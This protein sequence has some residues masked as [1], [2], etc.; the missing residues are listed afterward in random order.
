MT[1]TGETPESFPRQSARTRRFTLGEPRSF[2]ICGEGRR[3][4]FLRALSGTDA[5]TALWALDPVDG[6]ER[7]VVDP[8]TLGEDADLPE[9]ERA[10]RERVRETASGVVAYATDDAGET[11]AFAAAGVLW[12]VDVTGGEPRRLPAAPG[13]YDPRPD[14]TGTHI[15][16]VSGRELRVIAADGTGDRRIAGEDAE[17]VSW[18]R[19]EFV[20]AEEMDRQRGY[21]WSPDG[22]ALLAARVDE[23]PVPVWWIADPA[24][25]DRPPT[26][27]RYPAAGTDNAE[28]SLHVLGLDGDTREITWD[29]DGFPYL[30][31]VSW[32][33]A[34]PPLLQVQTRD[35]RTTR[36]L[37]VD[38]G[39]GDTSLVVE[40]TD[41]VWV[42][43]FP[44]VPA[45]SGDDVVR[46]ADV[47]GA[48]RLIVG[49]RPVTDPGLYVRGVVSADGSGVVFTASL[50]VPSEVHVARWTPDGVE[51]LT[52]GHTV[53]A[54]VAGEGVLVLSTASLE[55]HGYRHRLLAAGTEHAITSVVEA[56]SIE[57]AVRLLRLGERRLPAG[58]LLPRDHVPGTR[59]PVLLDP[60]GGPHA[61]RVL[62]ARRVWLESQW[63]ADQGF[64]VLVA[65]GRGTPGVGP[66]WERAV[67]RDIAE[68]VLADQAD[69]LAA[70]A[71]VE[72]DLDLGR[73]AIR[74]WSFGGYLA[75]LA[76][77]RRPDLFH[78]AVA[79]APSA[80][81]A[82]YDTHYTERYLGLPQDEPEAYRR[83]SLLDD[84]P[85]LTRPLLLIHGLADDNVV[86]AHTLLLSQRLTEA[87]RPHSVLPLTGVTHM[88]PQEA[89]AENLLLLQLEFLR[90]ALGV[91]PSVG[92]PAPL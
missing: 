25:P 78:A 47:G 38:P 66:D 32:A 86:A 62:A 76:V 30:A 19:A 24:H 6:T 26:P 14:P 33:N 58:L 16:Y 91:A 12:V 28:V 21:W 61:Q 29:R 90:Q 69:A 13:A 59:L 74:G 10:R 9:A 18:G 31:R 41:D 50:D 15:A 72:P 79:G 36:I 67:S 27:V 68:V 34:H 55:H 82:H 80:D 92:L 77:L 85:N 63:W 2:T 11:V 20:A 84:A 53:N 75:A 1:A 43:L 4:L 39:S 5:R 60:Y 71:E 81:W 44:G 17:T 52:D 64:A 70:A 42:E 89:V 51:R 73:V 3:V 22:S 65:E 49:D 54:A 56:P 23:A 8:R 40:D 46:I 87:G 57:P 45:W 83:T 7:M 48:R 35:Q 37:T 88:T